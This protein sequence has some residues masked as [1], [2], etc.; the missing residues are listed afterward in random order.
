MKSKLY[1][2]SLA[3]SLALVLPVQAGQHNFGGGGSGRGFSGGGGGSR[4][5]SA[6][7]RNFAGRAGSMAGP[8]FAN[9]R[10]NSGG[11]HVLARQSANAHPNWSHNHD[12]FWNG[13]RCR[14]VNGSWV[15]FDFGF[16]DP[17]YWGYPYGYPYGYGGYGY[18]YPYGYG[19]GYDPN[20]Q[21]V[22]DGREPGYQGSDNGSSESNS[23]VA[24]AQARLKHLGYYHGRV[25]GQI[26]PATE[27]AIAQYQR[28]HGQRVTGA[29]TRN[30]LNSIQGR[31]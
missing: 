28:D 13:H 5:S 6:P 25:D 12:H 31:E 4:P 9:G 29:V 21:G 20:D 24:V 15:I 14:F 10:F 7:S 19:Y 27:R 1:F 30:T 16:Y 22:Y 2:L 18:G 11:A 3:A 23:P 8:H 17:F 26:G